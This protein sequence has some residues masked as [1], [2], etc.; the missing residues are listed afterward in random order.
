MA[1]AAFWNA[2]DDLV[3]NSHVV[4]DRRKGSAHPH[5]PD[6]IYPVDY[7]YLDGTTAADGDGIDVWLGSTDEGQ[8]K[9]VICTIDSL[10]RDAEIKILLSCTPAE[11]E[12]IVRFFDNNAVGCLLVQRPGS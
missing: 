11:I 2:I 4:I 10:K 9:A 8:A 6:M 7:G 1:D 3:V 5:Y 12:Q